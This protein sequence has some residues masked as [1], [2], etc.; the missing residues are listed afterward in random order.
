M[1]LTM[2]S[3]FVSYR[4]E[5]GS[6]FAG[7]I[8]ADLQRRFGAGEVFRDVDDL[9][10]GEDFVQGLLRALRTCRVLIVVVGKSWLTAAGTGGARRLD[11]PRDFVRQEI[12]AA[13]ARDDVQVIPVLVEGA[14]MPSETDLPDELKP[15]ARRQAH[16]LADSRW[17]YDMGRLADTIEATLGRGARR[18]GATGRRRLV[19]AT[20]AAVVLA[21]AAAAG[22][23]F[24]SRPADLD[25]TWDLPNGSYWIVSQSG[26]ELTIQEVHYESRQVWKKGR[27]SIDGDVVDFKLGLVFEPGAATAGRLRIMAGGR[28][29]EGAATTLPRNIRDE[30]VLSRR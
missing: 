7:R 13:L 23:R 1:T 21:V 20:A 5:G 24:L 2:G 17:D 3:I 12:A 19:L 10:S 11:D 14:R 18:A 25:G 8:E 15:L 28:R 22:W 30:L 27:G 6:G 9:T 16:E 26:R 29:L 4:R